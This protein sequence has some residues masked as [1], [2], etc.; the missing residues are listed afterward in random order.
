MIKCVSV[1]NTGFTGAFRPLK[2]TACVA[3]R[4]CPTI[5]MVVPNVDW[6]KVLSGLA[7][8]VLRTCVI[9]GG[10][11]A[12][13]GPEMSSFSQEERKNI[14]PANKKKSDVPIFWKG[15][16]D[17]FFIYW[18]FDLLALLSTD[19]RQGQKARLE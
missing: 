9:T 7:G 3:A 13:R 10:A 5:T 14:P 1:A 2:V 4:F 18:F 11:E 8:L 12:T 16:L 17:L 6:V 15:F 19:Q